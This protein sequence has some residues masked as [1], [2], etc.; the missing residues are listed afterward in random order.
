MNKIHI[1]NSYIFKIQMTR[2]IKTRLLCKTTY[3]RLYNERVEDES[4]GSR[5]SLLYL[6][7]K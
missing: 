5:N 2:L 6:I 1:V 4:I 7:M 3:E